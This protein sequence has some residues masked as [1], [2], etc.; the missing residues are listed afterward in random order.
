MKNHP[1]TDSLYMPSPVELATIRAALRFWMEEM[2][3]ASESTTCH[4]FDVSPPPT[5]TAT[6]IE[7]LI[8][9]LRADDPND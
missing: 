2:S 8:E 9:R 6:E 1:L 5:L 4:Y 3:S 7:A